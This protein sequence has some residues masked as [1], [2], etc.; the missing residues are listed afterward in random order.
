MGKCWLMKETKRLRGRK[1]FIIGAVAALAVLVALPVTFC[2]G[3]YKV[4][5]QTVKIDLPEVQA[6]EQDDIDTDIVTLIIDAEKADPAAGRDAHVI[7]WYAGSPDL[8]STEVHREAFFVDENHSGIRKVISDRRE[9]AFVVKTGP[10]A[11][12]EA[13][14]IILDEININQVARYKVV[15]PTRID[16]LLLEKHGLIK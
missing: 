14:I 10:N 3:S 5:H 9:S 15:A 12:Y 6:E 1:W 11:T 4:K 2:I 8:D 16:T 13:V 7:Y